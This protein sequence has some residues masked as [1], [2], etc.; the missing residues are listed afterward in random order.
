MVNFRLQKDKITSQLQNIFKKDQISIQQKDLLAYG[1][2]LWPLSILR[3]RHQKVMPAADWVV[4]PEEEK[5]ISE[6]LRLANREKFPVT[7]YGEG[8]G[9][10]GGAVPVS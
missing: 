4:W 2:D 10:C 1:R 9:V 6:L 5:Q 3:L 7:P 8:S